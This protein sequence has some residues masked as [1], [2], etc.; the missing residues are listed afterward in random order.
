[1]QYDK[2]VASAE[3]NILVN[4]SDNEAIYKCEAHNSAIDIPYFETLKLTVYCEYF[5]LEIPIS[6]FLLPCTRKNNENFHKFLVPP[7]HAV[8]K[9]EPTIFRAGSQGKLVCDVSS[10]N[11]EASLSWW[12]EGLAVTEGVTEYSR[13]GLHGGKVSTIELLLNLTAELDERKYTCQAINVP[14]QR[15]IDTVTKLDVQCKFAVNFNFFK[16]YC[17]NTID[18]TVLVCLY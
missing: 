15:S 14:L 16:S 13:P 5:T 9:R 4:S 7:L 18:I 3:T 1:M 8:I 11:P 10:S 12:M 17:E 6:D 2:K